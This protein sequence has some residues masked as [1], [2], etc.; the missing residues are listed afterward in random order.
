MSLVRDETW[1][2]ELWSLFGVGMVILLARIGLRCWVYGFREPAAEDCLSVF[3]PAFYTVNAVGCY[4]V[5]INGN[6][7]DFTQEEINAL[8][9]EEARRLI[10]GTKWELALAYS[11]V[12]TLW[13]LKASL[14]LLYWRLTRNLGKH[15][16]LVLLIAI[17][18]VLAYVGVMLSMALSCIPSRRFWQIKPLP[19]INCVRPPNIF[20]ALTVS[21]VL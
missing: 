7:V 12:T 19:S 4:L 2:P 8:T 16:L 18:C 1:V 3:I 11:Y 14:L 15:R 9:D 20:I 21:N 6:K 10:F 17:T 13:L 5:Y